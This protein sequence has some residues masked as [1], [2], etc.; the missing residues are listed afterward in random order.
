MSN[1]VANFRTCTDYCGIMLNCEVIYWNNL[2]KIPLSLLLKGQGG[3]LG[4][5]S[6]KM[7]LSVWLIDGVEGG[8]F[9]KKF[10][11]M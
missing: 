2:H 10:R 3:Y 11:K 1:K 9:S 7:S 6:W 8:H 5:S 4:F